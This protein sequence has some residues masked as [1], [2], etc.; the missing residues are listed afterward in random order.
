MATDSRHVLARLDA[1]APPGLVRRVEAWRATGRP[2]AEPVLATSVVLLREQPESLEV[3][4]LQRHDRMLFAPGVTV[5]PGGRVDPVDHDHPRGPVVAAGVRET[6]EETSV[7]LE[8]DALLPWAHWITPECE[9]RRYDTHFFVALAPPGREAV[10]ISGETD[11]AWWST[12]FEALTA[13]SDGTIT[14]MPPTA[15]ILMELAECAR[16]ED[17]RAAAADRR[18]GP[19]LP[20]LIMTDGT[21]HFD[22]RRRGGVS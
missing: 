19:V 1:T 18:I 17:V 10:D 13:A 4:L 5:F 2:P 21:W 20:E 14:L 6:A 15:S 3:F 8:P 22:Y 9:P 12:P 11:R 16:W 7:V